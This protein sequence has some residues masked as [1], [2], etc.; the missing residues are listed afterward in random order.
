MPLHYILKN[1]LLEVEA[2]ARRLNP[3]QFATWKENRDELLKWIK[4]TERSNSQ[5]SLSTI[6]LQEVDLNGNCR[7]ETTLAFASDQ[8]SNSQTVHPTAN[9]GEL[10][11]NETS[12]QEDF[13]EL[14]PNHDREESTRNE[15]NKVGF[16]TDGRISGV[17]VASDRQNHAL[18]LESIAS[19]ILGLDLNWEEVNIQNQQDISD[20]DNPPV[21]TALDQR[22]RACLPTWIAVRHEDHTSA[23]LRNPIRQISFPGG[24]DSNSDLLGERRAS[25]RPP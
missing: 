20:G 14:V 22:R 1:A 3:M 5:I 13:R 23:E 19:T 17:L 9:S 25:H 21:S 12:Y 2:V 4:S 11:L 24:S 18:V 16:P 15:E 10:P 8:G 7:Q 6:S